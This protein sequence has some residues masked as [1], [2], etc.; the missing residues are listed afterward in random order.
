MLETVNTPNVVHVAPDP[1]AENMVA[2][3]PLE[4]VPVRIRSEI[5]WF[6]QV[7]VPEPALMVSPVVELE[8]ALDK[9]SQ[10]LPW[11]PFPVVSFPVVAM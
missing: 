9:V 4:R 7:K 11:L 8:T 6:P 2:G 3:T 10:G 5:V 1:P